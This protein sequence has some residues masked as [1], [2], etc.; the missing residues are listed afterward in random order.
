MIIA[1]SLSL[2]LLLLADEATPQQSAAEL[3]YDLFNYTNAP[4]IMKVLAGGSGFGP[5]SNWL[6]PPT[7]DCEAVSFNSLTVRANA[8]VY[9]NTTMVGSRNDQCQ[10]VRL[11]AIQTPPSNGTRWYSFV[12]KSDSVGGGAKGT[13][14]LAVALGEPAFVSLW[15]TSL[16]FMLAGP[17]GAMRTGAVAISAIKRATSSNFAYNIAGSAAAEAHAVDTK[18][19]WTI[20]LFIRVSWVDNKLVNVHYAPFDLTVPALEVSEARVLEKS[21]TTVTSPITDLLAISIAMSQ[22]Y[23]A[24]VRVGSTFNSV[25]RDVPGGSIKAT[26]RPTLAT[27]PST[28]AGNSTTTTATT[29]TTTT[30][31]T[32]RSTSVVGTS[33][34]DNLIATASA[35]SSSSLAGSGTSSTCV[36]SA[37]AVCVGVASCKWCSADRAATSGRCTAALDDGLGACDFV[38]LTSSGCAMVAE[39]DKQIDDG[40]LPV[41]VIAGAAGGGVAALLLIGLVVFLVLRSR[42]RHTK[43]TP[44]PASGAGAATPDPEMSTTRE[45]N[46]SNNLYG[47][48]R[49][50]NVY[51]VAGLATQSASGSSGGDPHYSPMAMK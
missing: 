2:G 1:L 42:R 16:P 31:T 41:S 33:A 3:A 47:D 11:L 25:H 12:F 30:T 40:S 14:A 19:P 39:P 29:T 43:Q 8:T 35:D 18:G 5:A 44:V 4:S 34:S 49:L 48:I 13:A 9:A 36:A 22:I 15:N 51:S 24:Q 37:C 46:S 45:A 50:T 6:A 10:I 20:F 17:P 38:T 23:V 28:T 7:A 27:T 21:A 26:V 32:A